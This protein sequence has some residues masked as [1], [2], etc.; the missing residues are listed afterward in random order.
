MTRTAKNFLLASSALAFG[1]GLATFGAGAQ[2]G[3]VVL[4]NLPTT[5]AL[6]AGAFATARSA[7]PMLTDISQL[8]KAAAAKVRAAQSAT[9]GSAGTAKAPKAVANGKSAQGAAAG[10]R[11]F[12][13][14]N[15]PF[16]T[17][18][19]YS[20]FT[21]YPVPL[22]PWRQAGKLLFTRNGLNFICSASLIR[23]G[24]AVTAAHCVNTFGTPTFNSA[25]SFQ[26]ARH[27]GLTP[28]GT[29]A[30]ITVAV[31]SAYVNG[32]DDC[33]VAGVVCANDVAL[34][35]LSSNPGTAI[36]WYGT[37]SN[38]FGYT[39]TPF[40]GQTAA[41]ITQLGYPGA[42]DSGNRMIRTDSLGVFADPNNVQIGSDQTGGSSGGPWL[43]N[44]GVAPS[45]TST[46]PS[47]NN[48]NLVVATTSWGFTDPN[49]KIQGASRFGNNTRFPAP[50]DTNITALINAACAAFPASC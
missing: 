9:R 1:A 39:N 33:T 37:G 36:G 35:I 44:F 18:G 34:V 24:I 42:F 22:T 25:T 19:A 2:A 21:Q 29:I 5:T 40:L 43:V 38:G 46:V 20:Q 10:T 50:G 13:T 30:A 14:G 45:S 27:D 41:Q 26:P 23:R 7:M 12:G 31:P 11:G 4:Y 17:K 15:H 48:S 3:D 6:Q 32:T 8:P 28:Y 16:T 47:E 49:I